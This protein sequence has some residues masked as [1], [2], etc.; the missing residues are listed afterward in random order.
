MANTAR[1]SALRCAWIALPQMFSQTKAQ[2]LVLPAGTGMAD[3][4]A[5]LQELADE[6]ADAGA[7]KLRHLK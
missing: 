1:V 4:K 7:S 3:A 5:A 2:W 6:L